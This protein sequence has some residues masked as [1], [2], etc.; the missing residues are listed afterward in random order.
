M[1]IRGHFLTAMALCF[2]AQSA[3]A[4][5]AS[6]AVDPGVLADTLNSPIPVQSGAATAPYPEAKPQPKAKGYRAG[7]RA[8]LRRER[9]ATRE[10]GY[11]ARYQRRLAQNAV[12]DSARRRDNLILGAGLSLQN[13]AYGW[14]DDTS[15]TETAPSLG[16]M[17]GYRN[18]IARKLG[19]KTALYYHTGMT[20]VNREYPYGPYGYS[21][22][23][24]DGSKGT[25]SGFEAMGQAVLG[26]LGRFAI[27][28]GIAY[29]LGWHSAK[30]IS[31]SG[32]MNDTY[33]PKPRFSTLAAV[34]GASLY[35]GAQDQINPSGW[36]SVG[37]V[38][39]EDD[40]AVFQL[41]LGFTVAFREG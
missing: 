3:P 39:G 6:S 1:R 40:A 38:L 37:K 20:T 23:H 15:D 7:D 5:E 10:R 36:V 35:L 19:F 21:Y 31:L 12:R 33:T 28:P 2:W 13:I 29:G 30:A 18:H 24:S 41:N 32:Y 4:A 26:P 8:A 14:S 9:L 25:T 27:E 16:L 22:R 11:Q 34:L 17:L